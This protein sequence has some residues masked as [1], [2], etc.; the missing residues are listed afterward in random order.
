MVLGE[1]QGV[2]EASWNSL[3]GLVRGVLIVQITLKKFLKF[4]KGE[5][6]IVVELVLL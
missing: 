4:V 6:F 2:L 1:I 5:V 3:H